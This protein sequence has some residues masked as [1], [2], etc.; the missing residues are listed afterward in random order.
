MKP[1]SLAVLTLALTAAPLSNLNAAEFGLG[2]SSYLGDLSG[3]ETVYGLAYLSD[4]T[5]VAAVNLGPINPGGVAPV[6]LNGA[7][8]ASA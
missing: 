5:L 2:A 6:Y 8:D 4:G 7:T 1:L 3:G